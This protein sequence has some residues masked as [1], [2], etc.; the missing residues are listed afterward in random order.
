MTDII[1]LT[2]HAKMLTELVMAHKAF[3]NPIQQ[4]L[5]YLFPSYQ[6]ITISSTANAIIKNNVNFTANSAIFAMA[7]SNLSIGLQHLLQKKM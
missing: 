4:S 2:R 5:H 3:L 7:T 1:V 6:K